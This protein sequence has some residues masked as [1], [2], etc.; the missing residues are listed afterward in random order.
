MYFGPMMQE[1]D[2][3]L[4]R[5]PIPQSDPAPHSW[6][7]GGTHF[8]FYTRYYDPTL[9]TAPRVDGFEITRL[10][11][12][13]PR[14]AEVSAAVYLN[15]PKVCKRFEEVSDDVDLVLI[16]DCNLNGEDHVEF[17]AP[18]LKK[19]VPTFVD[20]PFAPS[21]A[22]VNRIYAMADAT[23]TPVL[24]LSIMRMAPAG[25]QFAN[26]L[27]ELGQ[28]D[29]ATVQGY[30]DELNHLTHPISLVQNIFGDGIREVRCTPG[31]P[32][33]AI[34]LSWGERADR[35]AQGVTINNNTGKLSHGGSLVT[36]FGEKG[37]IHSVPFGDW[38]HPV[39]AARILEVVREMVRTRNVPIPRSEMTEIIAVAEAAYE[40][41]HTGR[42]V[43]VQEMLDRARRV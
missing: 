16:A 13:N 22:D 3:F 9:M 2:P 7:R 15:K 5:Q 21:V 25:R 34:H 42:P 31:N 1:H 27:P 41:N 11:D 36:A 24:S 37:A 35:P 14:V 29:F 23:N 28:C 4:L 40:S 19:G 8:Y 6:M 12:I 10:W 43:Q 18:G 26:R 30:G 32:M 38:E 33:R 20:K 39:G 17:A